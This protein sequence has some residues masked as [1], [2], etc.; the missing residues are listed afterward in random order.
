MHS[1][2]HL[3]PCGPVRSSDGASY[4]GPL[5]RLAAIRIYAGTCSQTV[6]RF[7]RPTRHGSVPLVSKQMRRIHTI[8]GLLVLSL[9]TSPV[10]AFAEDYTIGS[11]RI[12]HPWTVPTSGS[13]DAAPGYLTIT[14]TGREPDSLRGGSFAEASGVEV[15]STRQGPEA[16]GAPTDG[17][18][19][20]PGETLVLK[21]GGDHLMFV[22]LRSPLR[23]G[24]MEQAIVR[25]ERAGTVYVNFAVEGTAP[26]SSRHS[27]REK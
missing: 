12:G 21:P 7:G 9:A 10:A 22:G 20:K 25:F 23:S 17:L 1:P 3:L 14:N 8:L 2:M 11:L 5:P 18:V 16:K 6:L 24:A 19:I 27:R 13:V 15:R 4:A 26:K